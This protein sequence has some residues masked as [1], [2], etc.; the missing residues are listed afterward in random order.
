LPHGFASIG[1]HAS[2]VLGFS[3]GVMTR[4]C[5][6]ILAAAAALVALSPVLCAIALLIRLEDGGPALFMQTRI[7]RHRQLF[8]V[9]KF[10][11]MRDGRVTRVGA[12]LR[13]TGL[14]ELP[15]L[16]NV[17]LGEMSLVGPRPLTEDDV[18]RLGWDDAAHDL[19]WRLRPGI[20]GLAQLYAGRGARVSWF[21]D[22]RYVRACGARMDLFILI[23][24]AGVC[25]AGKRRVR[26]LLRRCRLP[27]P[28]VIAR[29]PRSF[30]TGLAPRLDAPTGLAS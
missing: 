26:R 11:S 19:R 3:R 30:P 21:L 15:Q 5:F 9:Y 22:R 16:A 12:W 8:R 17:V 2:S 24:T 18:R 20:A 28:P 29:G 14:D 10:R 7:G 27:K 1:R 6:D 23:A 25:F 4:R 13:A